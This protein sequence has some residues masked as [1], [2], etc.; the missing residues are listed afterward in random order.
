MGMRTVKYSGKISAP[1]NIQQPVHL[2]IKGKKK[3]VF[4]I[5]T[6]EIE[7]VCLVDSKA[8]ICVSG[9]SPDFTLETMLTNPPTPCLASCN[10][11]TSLIGM[12][13]ICILTPSIPLII[14]NV[15]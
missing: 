13:S 15:Y 12:G 9:D 11:I 2:T 3:K 8:D 1:N 7:D 14:Q 5:A 4:N 6:E 10:K